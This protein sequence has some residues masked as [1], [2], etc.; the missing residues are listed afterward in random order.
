MSVEIVNRFSILEQ[1]LADY[2]HHRTLRRVAA[3]GPRFHYHEFE[4]PDFVRQSPTAM[5]YYHWFRVL[6]W[7]SFPERNLNTI[8]RHTPIPHATF[9]AACL[10]KIDRGFDYMS[11]LHKYLR[12]HPGLT[13]LLGFQSVS[14]IRPPWYLDVEAM[15]PTARHFT[16]MLRQIPNDSLQTLLDETVQKIRLELK[17][18]IPDFGHQI[19][20]DTK[21]II[22]WVKENNLNTWVSD[23][24]DKTRQP[25]GDPDCRLGFKAHDNQPRKTSDEPPT[26]LSNSKPASKQEVGTFY[27]GYGTGVVATKIPGWGEFALAELTQPFN[28]SDVSYFEPLMEAT[29]KRLGFKPHFGTFDAAFDAFYVYAYFHRPDY[30]WQDGFAAVPFTARNSRRYVFDDDH[31]LLC[32]GGIVMTLKRTYMNRTSR[33]SHERGLYTC[34]LRG[35][36]DAVC[37]IDHPKWETGGCEHRIATSVGVRLRHQIDRTSDIYKAMYKQ[38]TAT[39]R[40]NSQ[41]EALGIETP[42]LRNGQAIANYNTLIY[43]VINLRALHRIRKKKQQQ[44]QQIAVL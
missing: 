15:L 25:A 44:R 20:L 32:Q 29:R 26:P 41:A 37:P 22:A 10:I 38:R 4:L 35:Q 43:T 30:D 7:T 6:D 21:H 16:R 27:W 28:E 5:G 36:T 39:E 31:R 40:I 9:A 13:W 1:W 24:Y 17:T 23:R 2:L 14:A 8:F 33:V 11:Q 12:E 18:M 42:R 19:S 34:P 3:P